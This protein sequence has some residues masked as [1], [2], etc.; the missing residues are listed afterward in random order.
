[1]NVDKIQCL[2]DQGVIGQEQAD[3]II[4]LSQLPQGTSELLTIIAASSLSSMNNFGT[5][6]GTQSITVNSSTSQALTP[7]GSKAIVTPH[8]NSAIFRTD[9]GAVTTTA[10]HFLAQGSN[11]IVNDLD[12]FRFC[13]A[14]SGY[15]VT[16]YVTYYA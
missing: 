12:N 14:S 7:Q 1:M 15:D 9:G 6:V 2:V 13:A 10:G 3:N 16:L 11:F 4:R 5:P 8:N